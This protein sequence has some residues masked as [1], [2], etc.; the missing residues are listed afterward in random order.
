MK[1]FAK[2][3]CFQYFCKSFPHLS[4][5][6]VKEGIF[7]GPDICKLMFGSNFQ[8]TIFLKEN[9]LGYQL[10]KLSL[11]SLNNMKAPNY[12]VTLA[13]MIENFKKP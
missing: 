1:Q 13:N 2:F 11:S 6:K 10:K 12:E 3:E 7:F 9:G 5:A 4:E 8:V